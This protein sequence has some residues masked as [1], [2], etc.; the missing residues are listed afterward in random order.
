[1]AAIAHKTFRG[2]AWMICFVRTGAWLM[3]ALLSAGAAQADN[4]RPDN[5]FAYPKA[6]SANMQRV[7]MLPLTAETRSADLPEG[8]EALQP[9]LFDELVRTKR[10]EVVMA[11]RDALRE[12]SGRLAWTGAE[13]LPADFFGSLRREYGCDGVL[14]C[15]LTVY[16]VYGPPVIGWRLKLVDARTREII[17]AADQVFD[18]NDA[19]VAKSAWRFLLCRDQSL[20]ADEARWEIL[21]SPRDFGHYTAARILGTLPQR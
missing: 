1:M 10:F 6:L 16:N 3:V 20:A 19:E 11:S 8:C 12:S 17:W 15:E 4:T 2:T 5:V 9:V 21:H 13:Q 14:F 7:V 18:A